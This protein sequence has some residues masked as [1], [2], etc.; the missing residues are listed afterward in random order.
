ML[1]ARVLALVLTL[2]VLPLALVACGDDDDGSDQAED[3]ITQAIEV[4]A[5]SQDPS[6]CTELQTQNFVR[7]DVGVDRTGGDQGLPE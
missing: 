1:R 5:T 3:Q 2:F 4:S 6:V 7:A